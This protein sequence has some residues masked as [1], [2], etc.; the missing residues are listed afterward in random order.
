MKKTLLSI[1]AT[2]LIA[3]SFGI[4]ATSVQASTNT[5]ESVSIKQSYPQSESIKRVTK[6]SVSKSTATIASINQSTYTVIAGDTLWGISKKYDVSVS[7]LKKWNNLSSNT[8]QIGQSLNVKVEEKEKS[9]SSNIEQLSK[10]EDKEVNSIVNEA[11][12]LIGTKYVFGGT[13]PKGFDCSGFIYYV[14]NQAGEK[15]DRTSSLG[16][17]NQ[18]TKV[19][20]PEVGDFVFFAG[21]YKSG[22]S[23]MGI[24]IGNNSFI[25]ASSS[26]VRITS[27]DDSYWSKYFHSFGRLN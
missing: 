2:V 23:H 18:S 15:L 25:H 13:S 22:I 21:T 24:Y 27:L 10:E 6:N 14:L 16:Y 20:S 17:Y 7:Q 3:S 9:D 12:K 11:T 4:G 26:G 19:T 5:N 8:L 1:S